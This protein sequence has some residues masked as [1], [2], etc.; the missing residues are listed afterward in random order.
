MT[1]ESTYIHLSL[2]LHS[3]KIKV[4]VF[5]FNF[6]S[7]LILINNIIKEAKNFI[8]KSNPFIKTHCQK[9]ASCK[10]G[11]WDHLEARTNSRLAWRFPWQPSEQEMLLHTVTNWQHQCWNEFSGTYSLDTILTNKRPKARGWKGTRA[12]IQKDLLNAGS[13]TRST[14]ISSKLQSKQQAHASTSQI[15][16]A[17]WK[18][19]P[20]TMA[21]A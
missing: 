12:G 15:K 18:T 16:Q 6:F 19:P 4:T 17:Y 2:L 10:F 20:A 11:N 5:L 7:N 9:M 14:K 13:Q 8:T 1:V 21:W 3:C